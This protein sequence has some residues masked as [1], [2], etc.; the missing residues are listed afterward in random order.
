MKKTDNVNHPSHYTM[1]EHEVIE[2][3]RCLSFDAGNACKYIIRAPFKESSNQDLK[4]AIWYAKDFLNS[5]H[6]VIEHTNEQ[7]KRI[8]AL[9]SY[10]AT[11][12]ASRGENFPAF[13][14]LLFIIVGLDTCQTTTNKSGINLLSTVIEICE[15]VL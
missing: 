14:K 15:K 3:T 7:R 5:K 2:L 8:I 10:F 1:Y 9:A 4:K 11:Q 13:A 6:T 12:I